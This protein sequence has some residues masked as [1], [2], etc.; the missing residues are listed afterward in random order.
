MVRHHKKTKKHSRRRRMRGGTFPFT[1][2]DGSPWSAPAAV[3]ANAAPVVDNTIGTPA[4]QADA[5]GVTPGA[6]S[7]PAGAVAPGAPSDPA[8]A[9]APGATPLGGR[10]RKTR[11][12]RKSRRKH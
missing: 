4:Q 3:A 12:H 1:R 11:K 6:P 10:R 8:G 5:L 7:D 9:V 2:W